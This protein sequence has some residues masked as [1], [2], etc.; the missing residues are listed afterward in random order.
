MRPF[1]AKYISYCVGADEFLTG[2]AVST[3]YAYLHR[4]STREAEDYLA[5]VVLISVILMCIANM[6]IIIRELIHRSKS[7]FGPMDEKEPIMPVFNKPE[8]KKKE[9]EAAILAGIDNPD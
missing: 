5:M 9:R 8:K 2:V 4:T 6:A 7:E 1:R 3:Y